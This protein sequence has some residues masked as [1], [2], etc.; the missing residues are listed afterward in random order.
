M[1]IYSVWYLL[2]RLYV[3][4]NIKIDV[5]LNFVVVYSTCA[6]TL[7][8][9]NSN[10]IEKYITYQQ[11][12]TFISLKSFPFDKTSTLNWMEFIKK[13]LKKFTNLLISNKFSPCL[14]KKNI[15]STFK[16]FDIYQIY[17]KL[18][19]SLDCS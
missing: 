12:W 2:Y 5:S 11:I 19:Q 10:Y 7:S 15:I 4:L 13:I 18:L 6:Y 17:V 8:S 9:E 1:L 3:Y 16:Y 14:F